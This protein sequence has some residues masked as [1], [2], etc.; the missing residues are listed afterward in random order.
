LLDCLLM[1]R[2]WTVTG[3]VMESRLTPSEHSTTIAALR[4]AG[5][6]RGA[7]VVA[8]CLVTACGGKS[9]TDEAGSRG[10]SFPPAKN[11]LDDFSS[12]STGDSNNTNGLA[13]N[14]VRVT[15]EVP[16]AVAPDGEATRRNLRI[17]APDRLEV[18][19]TDPSLR[20]LGSVDITRRTEDNGREVITFE[21]GLPLAP[22]V[23]IEAVYGNTRMRA[24]A[25]D[26]DR[27][28]KVNPFSEYL[29]TNTL[30]SYSG[31][32]FSDILDCVNDASG[33]LCLN[34]YVWSTLADQVHDFEIDIPDNRDL[35]GALELL[36][37]R[38]DFSGYVDRMAEYAVLNDESSGRI[39]ASSADYN[40]VFLGV[41]LGQTFREASLSGSGQW[42]LRTAQEEQ[43]TDSNGTGYVFP[44]LTLTTFD[45]FN[46][47]VTSLASDIP[48]DREVLI[49]RADNDFFARGSEEWDLN[50]HASAPGAATLVDETRLLAGRALYQSVTGQGSS[51]IIGWTRNPYYL[52][53]FVSTASGDNEPPDRV[54]SGYFTAGKAIELEA[55][56]DTLKRRETLED[57]YLSVLEV[58]LLRESG[59]SLQALNNKS[60]NVV[61]LATRLGDASEP[62]QV[63]TGAGTWDISGTQV[64]QQMPTRTIS[65]DSSGAVNGPVVGSR[66]VTWTVS[67]RPSRLSVGDRN[68]GRLNLDVS[69]ASGQFDTP[70]L[71]TGASNPE[72][73]LLA[74]NLDNGTTGDGLLVAATQ[75]ATLPA[76]GRYRLQGFAMGLTDGA[77]RLRHFDNAVLTIDS[78]ASATLAINALDVAHVV[79]DES[80]SA[81][82]AVDEGT[83]NLTYS[84]EGN[85]QARFTSGDLELEGFVTGEQ[86]QFFLRLSDAGGGEQSAGLVIATRLPE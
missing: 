32:Q 42:G 37:E 36:E 80:V 2:E 44:A 55:T 14:E 64:I 83:L 15:M 73:S 50:T 35:A 34:K 4:R 74:F 22:D 72:G 38:G 8:V 53:A 43:I 60:Y 79:G 65:R 46:I 31:T 61:Y 52:D 39:S 48:Y 18:Y 29:V 82:V 40:S 9:A 70:E 28:V 20:N 75:A 6:R 3:M 68:I 27:D 69:N 10:N 76:S 17:V 85:G 62:V 5:L 59:F 66:N 30:A 33:Q 21:N 45:A 19:R 67:E 7:L 63:E 13:A 41:E 86:D 57:H 16:A 51:E 54:L 11:A 23:I 58:N 81:P 1:F 12:G 84:D 78:N 77:N 49:H 26:S 24:L 71:G 56:S 25:A 47:R